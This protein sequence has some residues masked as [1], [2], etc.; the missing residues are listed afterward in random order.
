MLITY[1][2]MWLIQNG[3]KL[4]LSGLLIILLTLS[5]IAHAQQTQPQTSSV[6]QKETSLKLDDKQPPASLT[7]ESDEKNDA[8]L[9]IYQGWIGPN[10]FKLDL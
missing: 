9:A 10:P 2:E 8:K 3:V 6:N 1:R 5:S 4:G 7:T